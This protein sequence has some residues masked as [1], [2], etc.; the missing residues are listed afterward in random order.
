MKRRHDVVRF[1]SATRLFDANRVYSV[2]AE[3]RRL[4]DNGIVAD[5]GCYY[6]EEFAINTEVW[7]L[8]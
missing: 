8:L 3:R 6:S 7:D 2:K 1:E 5:Y 4:A